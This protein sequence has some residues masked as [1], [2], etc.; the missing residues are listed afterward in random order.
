MI[1]NQSH[2]RQLKTLLRRSLKWRVGFGI[3]S[4]VMFTRAVGLFSNLEL[5]AIDTFFV[6]R[7]EERPDPYI[8]IIGLDTDYLQGQE[9]VS[10]TQLI[11]LIQ[12][13]YT[14]QPAVVGLNLTR[15]ALPSKDR[16]TLLTLFADHSTLIS[17]EKILPPNPTFPL[18]G[19]PEKT[20]KAQIGF[21]DQSI[22]RDGRLRRMFLGLEDS[23]RQFKKSF[24][25]TICEVYLS[26]QGYE[27]VNGHI[28][29]DAM[30]FERPLKGRQMRQ[31]PVGVEIPR[32]IPSSGGYTRELGI[33]GVQ[34]LVNFRAGTRPFEV[35]NASDLGTILLKSESLKSP[36]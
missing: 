5:L 10:D 3:I 24:S 12:T 25:L 29:Q 27:L 6:Y 9:T 14:H 19:L 16:Q 35:I 7:A 20:A 21:N 15:E 22:D 2:L 26:T 4:L 36:G 33:Q 34:T 8:T 17:V 18:E 32:L 23:N 31:R 13:L 11:E 30:R 28:D 1:S